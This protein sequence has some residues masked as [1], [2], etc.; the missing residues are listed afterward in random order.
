MF[1]VNFTL[2]W[3]RRE[4]GGFGSFI[5]IMILGILGLMIVEKY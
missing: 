2:E 3:V 4:G 1:S 5:V